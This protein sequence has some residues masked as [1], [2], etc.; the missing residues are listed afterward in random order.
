MPAREAAVEEA[1]ERFLKTPEKLLQTAE[2]E[3]RLRRNG[4]EV[5]HLTYA[6]LS[7]PGQAQPQETIWG[8]PKDGVK[9]KA[10]EE[11]RFA[12]QPQGGHP[13]GYQAKTA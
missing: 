10:G 9:R 7:V 2:G 1:E 12:N 8:P 11:S 3:P 4:M 6:R 5:L 13:N